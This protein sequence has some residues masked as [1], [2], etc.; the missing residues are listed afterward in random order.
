MLIRVSDISTLARPCY[1]DEPLVE[2]C[3][4]EATDIDIAGT[5]GDAVMQLLQDSE[6][7]R[8]AT[9]L[10]GGTWSDCHGTHTF[11]GVKVALAYY[12]W[13]RATRASIVTASRFGA[14]VK[15]ED[16]S[17][18]TSAQER[19]QAYGEAFSLGD[20][21][22]GEVVAYLNAHC[23]DYPEWQKS[24]RVKNQRNRIKILGL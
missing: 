5:L 23:D 13:A 24:G 16:Y 10:N 4:D 6:D 1:I 11:K 14:V 22:L 17:R 3:I 15:Q 19:Q 2:R 18:P 21:Y 7:E 8:A 20:H 12:A 9:L